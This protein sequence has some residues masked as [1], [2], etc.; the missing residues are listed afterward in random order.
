MRLNH[1]AVLAANL[2]LSPEGPGRER[3]DRNFS[4]ASSSEVR[5]AAV[6]I[7][8]IR[9]REDRPGIEAGVVLRLQA[10]RH[11]TF[12]Q[13]RAPGACGGI[14]I[15]PPLKGEGRSLS[16][17]ENAKRFWIRKASGVG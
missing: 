15:H 13:R 10:D 12:A 3:S 4:A 14:M 5:D 6:D 17:S 1:D 11:A 2:R 7:C 16:E 8:A 9:V